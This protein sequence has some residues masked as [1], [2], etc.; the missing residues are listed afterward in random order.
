MSAMSN[1]PRKITFAEMRNMGVRRGM[2]LC[3]VLSACSSENDVAPTV[4]VP[5]F[6]LLR[7]L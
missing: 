2:L 4:Y 6:P 7:M 5:P 3:L 1:R